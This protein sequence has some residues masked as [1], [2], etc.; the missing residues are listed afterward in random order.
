MTAGLIV[1]ELNDLV[2]ALLSGGAEEEA[3]EKLEVFVKG[4]AVDV[5]D[6]NL[7]PDEEV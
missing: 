1:A 7:D 2:S 6:V 4:L 3:D 5:T